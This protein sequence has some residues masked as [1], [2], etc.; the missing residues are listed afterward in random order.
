MSK[1]LIL[2]E[3]K[4]IFCEEESILKCL[5]YGEPWREFVGD[6]AVS[7]LFDFAMACLVELPE[8]TIEEITDD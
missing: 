3:G 5:R 7:A 4:Y 8:T 2:C 6:K 1:A